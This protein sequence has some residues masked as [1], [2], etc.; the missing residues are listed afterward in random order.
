MQRKTQ[1]AAFWRNQFEVTQDD[2][3]FIHELVLDAS[4]PLTTEQLSQRLIEEYQRRETSRMESELSKG[5]IYQP[6]KAYAVGQTL[7]FPTMDFAVAEIT[8]TRPGENP[9]H[10]DFSVIEVQFADNGS[11]REFAA[12]LKTP[13]RLNQANGQSIVEKGALLTA[14]EIYRLYRD[15]IDES[16]LYALEEG[17]RHTEFVQVGEY[18]LLSDMLADVHVGHLNIA[19]A[20]IEMQSRPLTSQE[21]LKE[22]D[23]GS[24]ISQPMRTISINHALSGD[25][26]FDKVGNGGNHLW[27]LKRLE[28]KEALEIPALLRPHSPRYNRALLSVELLQL[29][30]ELDDEWGESGVGS[31]VPSIVPS[32]SFTLIYP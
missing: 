1:T 8:A 30:W 29:E 12:S 23:L 32:T 24:H 4:S 9:E 14:Q 5:K 2:L 3:D 26:R 27:Y 13:H 18:W 7:V 16:V 25:D 15:E 19:E 17:E 10:G 28:P 21:I 20:L 31:D 22:I 6:D 11:K